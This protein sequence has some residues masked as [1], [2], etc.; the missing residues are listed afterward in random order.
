MK[1]LL[2][3]I[4]MIALS[5]IFSNKGNTEQ[6]LNEKLYST[7]IPGLYVRKMPS[8][9][10]EAIGLIKYNTELTVLE[11]SQTEETINGV[12]APWIKIKSADEPFYDGIEGWIF[13]GFTSKTIPLKNKDLINTDKYD[14]STTIKLIDKTF[15]VYLSPLI[16]YL[17]FRG[18]KNITD[19]MFF[20]IDVP[21]GG[22]DSDIEKIDYKSNALILTIKHSNEDEEGTMFYSCKIPK[23]SILDGYNEKVEEPEIK[24]VLIKKEK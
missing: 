16:G 11:Y 6:I 7:A 3:I 10:A 8:T 20:Y 22:R 18:E 24:C 4:T 19:K 12:K 1:K 15:R 17:I 2:I 13:G 9:K 14:V 21:V 23:E 5:F